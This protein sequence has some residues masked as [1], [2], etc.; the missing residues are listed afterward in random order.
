MVFKVIIAGGRNYSNYEELKVVCDFYLK[1]KPEIEI[2]CG[3]ANG[4][5]ALGKKYGIDHNHIVSSFPA[6]W[7][8]YGK[9]AGYKRNTE[10]AEVADALIA[11]WDGESKGTKHMI[12][13][14]NGLKKDVRIF[15]YDKKN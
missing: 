6:N 2:I 13:I 11:F 7:D 3:G 8:K 10:M 12:D 15:R 4:A 5:D 1:L 9:S 14:M